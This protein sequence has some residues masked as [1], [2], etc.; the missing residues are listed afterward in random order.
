M[1]MC[2]CPRAQ[3]HIPGALFYSS[4]MLPRELHI[5][6]A[7]GRVR[8]RDIS[9]ALP[10]LALCVLCAASGVVATEMGVGHEGKLEKR[11]L[12]NDRNA[13]ASWK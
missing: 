5:H 1:L 12:N 9:R 11:E 4:A 8:R 3:E 6:R 10:E 7:E 13:L 2:S